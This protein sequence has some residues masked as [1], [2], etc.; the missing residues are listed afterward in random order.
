MV[1]P[2]L[3]ERFASKGI[4]VMPMPEGVAAFVRELQHPSHDSAE[5]DIVLAAR[6]KTL[7]ANR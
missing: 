1:T 3:R 2:E 7:A 5:V 6:L 4:P